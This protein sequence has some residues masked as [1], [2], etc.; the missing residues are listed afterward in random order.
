MYHRHVSIV[1]A[2]PKEPGQAVIVPA[3]GTFETI[4]EALA[5]LRPV[6]RAITAAVGGH[7]E[8]VFHDLSTGD[9]SHTIV[10]IEN[11]HVTGRTVGGPSTNLGIDLLNDEAAEHNAFGYRGRTA[12]GR[13]LHSS[14][15]YY[16]NS[17]GH[18]IAALC[19]N[20][21]LTQL[22]VA[23]SAIAAMLPSAVTDM[24][25]IEIAAPDITSIL[26]EMFVDAIATI[27]KAV[28]LM[29]KADRVEIL[30]LLDARG[31]FR[32][33]RALDQVAARLGIS[34]VTAYGYLDEIRHE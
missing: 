2:P 9:P 22:Q 17:A 14:S 21:D 10:A 13:E 12:D 26:D 28:P 16:R 33:R 3:P 29:E 11:G 25:E 5:V 8:V 27:G 30:R 6:M 20:V 15:V 32:V 31:A 4:D 24:P 23:Q 34:R 7:C 18:I 19:I 1:A